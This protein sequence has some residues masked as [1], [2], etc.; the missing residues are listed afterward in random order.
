MILNIVILYYII[1]EII[2]YL[3]GKKD[4]IL[5]SFYRRGGG[6]LQDIKMRDICS[7]AHID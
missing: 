1:G 5:P 4:K 3:I 2:L 6:L 7:I